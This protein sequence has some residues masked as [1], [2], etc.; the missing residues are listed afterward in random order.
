MAQRV[1]GLGQNELER[2]LV[3]IL[4]RRY[5]RKAADEFRYQAVFEQVLRLIRQRAYQLWEEDGA[6]EGR[7]EEYWHR[8]RELIQQEER[9]KGPPPSSGSFR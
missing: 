5:D 1:L 2:R 6:P 7:A 4:E 8:A 9:A 3:K